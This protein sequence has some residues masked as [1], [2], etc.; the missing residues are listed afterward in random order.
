MTGQ[1]YA[2]WVKTNV[3]A[4]VGAGDMTIAGDTLASRLPN[5]VVYHSSSE[6]PYGM[7][8]A[9]M[10]SHGGWLATPT[11]LVR[12]AVRVDGFATKPDILS[13]ST[14]AT[15]TTP[16]A[17]GQTYA[18]GWAVNNLNNWWHDGSL[19][20]TRSILVR[21]SGGFTWAAVTN[22]RDN[23]VDLDPCMWDVVNAVTEWP[24]YDRF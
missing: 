23:G 11:D 3:L 12:L 18:M 10:D 4:P 19:P 9:R 6:N 20:G 13:A 8:V 5:E 16:W 1:S 7:Q 2:D 21:T 22:S 15:M 17:P 24:S 14:I